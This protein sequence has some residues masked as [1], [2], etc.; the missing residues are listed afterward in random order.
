MALFGRMP[1]GV[2]FQP[3]VDGTLLT[4]R[5]LDAIASGACAGVPLLLG[6]NLDEWKLF[7]LADPKVRALDDDG[8][9]ERC[10][11]VVPGASD[12]GRAHADRVIEVYR[13]ARDGGANSAPSELWFAIEGDRVF[14]LPAVRL[15]E[16]ATAHGSPVQ[17]YLFSYGSP[18]LGGILGSCHALEVPFVFGT[19]AMPGL[20]AFVG[21]GTAVDALSESMQQA[22]LAFARGDSVSS[23]FGGWEQYETERRRTLRTTSNQR[24]KT[25]HRRR[26]RRL[27]D[28][29]NPL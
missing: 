20:R 5:P 16:A 8:L 13:A 25:R 21:E 27:T 29:S 15:A 1:E 18:A 11:R 17:K 10:A 19:H 4:K 24:S 2:P 9:R 23:G 6:T 28:C 14:R 22:W 12:G 26:T 3:V 7:A